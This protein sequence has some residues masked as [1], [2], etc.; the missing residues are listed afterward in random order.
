MSSGN[1]WV[2]IFI[3]ITT[4]IVDSSIILNTVLEVCVKVIWCLPVVIGDVDE[5]LIVVEVF[6]VL[7]GF[8]PGLFKVPE[9]IVGVFN[10]L[11]GSVPPFVGPFHFIPGIVNSLTGSKV[12]FVG[13]GIL[14]IELSLPKG[15]VGFI[16][17]PV[18]LIVIF[19]GP[20]V[21]VNGSLVVHLGLHVFVM[22]SSGIVP[23][24]LK[25][26][27]LEVILEFP[28]FFLKFLE[29]IFVYFVL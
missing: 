19:P 24:L 23:E 29:F 18:G 28:F 6:V 17:I 26:E 10:F 3:N 1:N 13:E 9:I 20:V 14:H 5:V 27:F 21:S 22:G 16:P 7:L 15:I 4:S 2:T 11:V 12:L 8:F 25:F